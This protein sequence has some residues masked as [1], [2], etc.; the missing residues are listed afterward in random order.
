MRIDRQIIEALVYGSHVTHRYTQDS[1]ILA[2]VWV[3]YG[4]EPLDWQDLLVTPEWGYDAGNMSVQLRNHV[5][6]VRNLDAPAY[7]WWRSTTRCPAHVAYNQVYTAARLY[8]DELIRI[9]LPMTVWWEELWRQAIEYWRRRHEEPSGKVTADRILH[10]LAGDLRKAL[11]TIGLSLDPD[12]RIMREKEET[13]RLISG[14]PPDLPWFI[15]I[16]GVIAHA[17]ALSIEE[18]GE[19]TDCDEQPNSRER[20]E[21]RL[22]ANDWVRDLHAP[23]GNDDAEE[24]VSERHLTPDVLIEAACD[25]M[26][27]IDLSPHEHPTD[28]DEAPGAES[29]SAPAGHVHIVNL[30]R[31]VTTAVSRSRMAVKADAAERLFAIDTSAIT[32]GIIDSG[33]DATHP[34]FFRRPRLG[35]EGPKTTPEGEIEEGEWIRWTRVKRTYDFTRIRTLL[36]PIRLQDEAALPVDLRSALERRP[37]VFDDLKA[38]LTRG[39]AIDWDLLEPFLRVPHDESYPEG[40]IPSVG[41]GT[42]VAGILAA[43]W[44]ER[45]IVG[46]C[47]DINLYDLR[48]LEPGK[49]NDEFAVLAAL[50]F[51]QWLNA[52]K[53]FFAVHGVNLSLSIRH[54]VANFACG[55]TPVCDQCEDLIGSGVTVVAAA[56]NAGY[57]KYK[58]ATGPADT[59]EETTEG[60]HTVS[61]TDPGNADRVI[62]VGSTHRD[63]P[64][65]YGVSYFS[66]RGPTGDGRRKPDLV[67]PGEKITSTFPLLGSRPLDGTSMAAPHVSGAAAMLMARH[68]ELVGQ[69]ERIKEALCGTATDLGR[70][71][72]FQGAGLLDVLRA[73]Q[74][75]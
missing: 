23:Y 68:P 63:K 33:I 53:D 28:S 20:R 66:S 41:H 40:S 9:V 47:K 15:R 42:H 54:E 31:P 19:E 22:N 1:P 3:R 38:S 13:S 65:Q 26:R 57:L 74:S 12:D 51:V 29:E 32:W 14:L 44:E 62:T 71:P 10:D 48:V 43:D 25:L 30:N 52:Q 2:D 60:Y 59:G 4:E 58:T 24:T 21:R 18:R 36:D 39:R 27:D 46:V 8:F 67:A 70:E 50:Q 55:R 11:E 72:Y 45:E 34:A 64:H 56:G 61:I 17:S 6:Q 49:P 5:E 16:V 37:V 35:E 75:V 73:L 69:P 7:T